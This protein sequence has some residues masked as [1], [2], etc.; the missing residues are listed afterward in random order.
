MDIQE[1]GFFKYTSLSVSLRHFLLCVCVCYKYLVMI[2]GISRLNVS[3]INDQRA[4]GN[5]EKVNTKSEATEED[6][7]RIPQW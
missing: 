4:L 2:I 7:P 1:L 5:P 3:G 6:R